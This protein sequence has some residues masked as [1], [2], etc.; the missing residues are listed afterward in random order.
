MDEKWNALEKYN[1]WK[2]NHY[3]LGLIRTA[4]LDKLHAFIGNRLVKV[5]IGQRRADKS[6][7]LRQIAS[8]LV[9]R[10]GGESQQDPIHKQGILGID[11]ERLS[12]LYR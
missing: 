12:S 11:T 4:Y 5:L 1:L 3:Q 2:G 8:E 9:S 10:Q 7:L 6:Y